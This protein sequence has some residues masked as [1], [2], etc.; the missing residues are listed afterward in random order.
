FNG[1]MMNLT[2]PAHLRMDVTANNITIDP[3]DT[4]IYIPGLPVP[5]YSHLGKVYGSFTYKGEPLNFQTTFDVR[6]TAGNARGFYDMNL[7]N[8]NIIYSSSF[9]ASNV[10]IGKII[11]D[12]SLE[13]DINGRIE[14]T[15][16]GFSPANVNT[17]IT[18]DINNTKLYG[19]SIDKSAGTISLRNYNADL[20]VTYAA[21]NLN[22]EVAGTINYADIRNPKYSL[23]GRINSLNIADFTKNVSDNSRLDF[24]FDVNGSGISA[25]NLQG[26]YNIQL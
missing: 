13:S 25:N 7:L 12:Q 20:N 3:N 11:K 19:Q 5:D 6:S 2:D 10:N 24:T 9:E 21:K 18:Y 26:T 14:F 4:K 1:K 22:T 17:K 23:K 16:S 15:G 8:P